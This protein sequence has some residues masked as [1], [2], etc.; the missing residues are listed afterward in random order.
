M[1]RA[2]RRKGQV[3]VELL[4]VLPIFMLMLFLIMELGN[5]AFQ[6]ILAHHSAYELAR[7]GALVAGPKGGERANYCD[8]GK[9]EIKMREVL[10]EMFANCNN[11]TVT[12]DCVSTGQDRQVRDTG[13]NPHFNH[14]LEVT[15][16]YPARLVFPG[17]SF[18]LSDPPRQKH[19]KTIRVMMRM[20][21]EKPFFQ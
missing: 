19:S 10:C 9:A 18:V 13:G 15:M 8:K 11:I 2:M 14:D 12:A 4:L 17:A 21:V 20:P 6:T 5:L 7:I 3:T 16:L 1:K